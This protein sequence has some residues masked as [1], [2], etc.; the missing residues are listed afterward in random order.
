MYAC[1][2]THSNNIAVSIM[3]V[4]SN[5]EPHTIHGGLFGSS[6]YFINNSLLTDLPPAYYYCNLPLQLLPNMRTLQHDHHATIAFIII[7]FYK[8]SLFAKRA[9]LL[10][11]GW[12]CIARIW[13]LVA[14]KYQH[15]AH[16]TINKKAI[17]PMSSTKNTM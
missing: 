17:H 2:T 11:E 14:M 10:I 12:I 8:S 4:Q 6:L 13:L 9:Q 1:I 7:A 15:I 5:Y 3:L 16:N